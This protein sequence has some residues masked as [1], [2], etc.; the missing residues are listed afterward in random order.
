MNP[1]AGGLRFPVGE[2]RRRREAGILGK[3]IA[4]ATPFVHK[5]VLAKR[6]DIELLLDWHVEGVLASL[7]GIAAKR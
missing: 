6:D 4:G 1:A 5:V 3:E 2:L 7:P